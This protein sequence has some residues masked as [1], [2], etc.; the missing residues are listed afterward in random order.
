MG[1]TGRMCPSQG[2]PRGGPHGDRGGGQRGGRGYGSWDPDGGRLTLSRGSAIPLLGLGTWDL[3]GRAGYEA[4]RDALEVGYRHIDT[5]TGYGNEAEVGRAVHD[6]GLPREEV[7]V[8]TK[9]APE[10]AGRPAAALSASLSRLGMDY[11]DLWL[12]HWPPRGR[13]APETWEQLLAARDDR[14]ARDVGVSNYSTAQVDELIRTSGVAPAVNQVRWG[15][16]LYDPRFAAEC[17]DRGLVLEGYSPLR[18]S[19]LDD[20]VLMEVARRYGVSTAQ[21]IIRWH[22]EH[23]VV[24]IPK[25]GSRERLAE[26]FGVWDWSL[27]ERE[28]S[29]VDGLSTALA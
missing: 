17:R 13:A 22:I 14:R 20:P 3:R 23:R 19:R 9:L 18:S 12:V 28:M 25:S 27:G 16:T 10:D 21:V 6:S 1:K 24:V 29:Q 5:A 11:V 2:G 8:T 4:I 26:N 15:P 7:F